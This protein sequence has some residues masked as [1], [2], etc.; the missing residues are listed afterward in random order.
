MDSNTWIEKWD[1]TSHYN[2]KEKMFNIVDEYVKTPPNNILDIGCGLAF[3]SEMFQKKYNCNLY[4]LDG[5]FENTQDRN[6][7]VNYGDTET[8]AFYSKVNDLKESWNS[9]GLNYNFIDANTPILDTSVTFDLVYSFE[10]CGFHYP[11]STYKDFLKKYTNKDTVF[12]FDIRRKNIK[13]QINDFN[14]VDTLNV[15]KKYD[16]LCIRF[17]Y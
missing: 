5:D 7:K 9:R 14:V 4:L 11:L 3:E 2:K 13:D 12:I 8:M 16:T 1:S 10:S 15:S 6:R 17:K